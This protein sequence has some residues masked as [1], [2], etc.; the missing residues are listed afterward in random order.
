MRD[1]ASIAQVH[2]AAWRAAYRGHMPD[3]YL[4]AL[5]PE[6]RAAMW[7]N[8]I[9]RP[10]TAVLVAEQGSVVVGFCSFLASSRD[11]DAAADIGE[12]TALYV[13]PTRWQVGCGSEL[14]RRTVDLARAHGCAELTLWVLAGNA[15]ARTF[16][17]ARGFAC[18]GASKRAQLG[19]F[20]IEEVRYRL[21]CTARPRA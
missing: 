12:I 14:L 7:A 13:D 19:G 15:P 4:Q 10:G 1:A 11:A 21:I 18:D 9:G 20:E 5:D 6:K 2:V 8:N 3:D 17:E 16:Y